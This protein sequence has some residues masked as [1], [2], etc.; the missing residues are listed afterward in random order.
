AILCECG[1]MDS[2]TDTPLIL[3][4]EF[5]QQA[6]QGLCDAL[7]EVYGLQSVSS[8][9]RPLTTLSAKEFRVEVV[10][11][12]KDEIQGDFINAGYFGLYKENGEDFALPAGHLAGDYVATGSTMQHYAKERGAFVGGRW[13]FD[14]GKWEYA[15]PNYGKALTTVYTLQ[16]DETNVYVKE[17]ETLP[18]NVLYAVSG[19]P[20]IRNGAAVSMEQIR[21][22]GWDASP[23]RAAWHTV[24]VVD[25]GTVSVFPWQSKSDNLVTSG[26]GA[27]AF[28]G[29]ENVIKLDGGGSFF[30]RYRGE[31]KTSGGSRVIC[32]ILRLSTEG[33]S[34]TE[35]SDPGYDKFKIYMS[36]YRAEQANLMADIWAKG[37]LDEAVELGL[38][39]GS[40][41]K[42]FMTREEGALMARAAVMCRK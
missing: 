2:A 31:E 29:H 13:L 12:P 10:S 14:S 36:R 34:L 28:A 24:L 16:G 37:F 30:A 26:E 3:T 40:R 35:P 38:T 5:S 17:M 42:D 27:K 7:V 11:M 1:F 32:S 41:P 23:F 9:I 21:A 25:G 39:D 15:N 4:E 22:Q 6:A 19:I 18:E 20:I 33:D 8:E